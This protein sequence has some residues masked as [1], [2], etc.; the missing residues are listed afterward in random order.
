MLRIKAILKIELLQKLQNICG[1]NH[2]IENATDIS[3]LF[4]YSCLVRTQGHPIFG[5]F[6]ML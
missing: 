5:S 3:R 1:K 4:R 2:I 6:D